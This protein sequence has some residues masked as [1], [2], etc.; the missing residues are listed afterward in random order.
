MRLIIALFF[1]LFI[2]LVASME[3]VEEELEFGGRELMGMTCGKV[4]NYYY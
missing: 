1:A 2:S 4:S 3:E